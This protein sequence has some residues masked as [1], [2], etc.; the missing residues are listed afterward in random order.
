MEEGDLFEV[1]QLPGKGMG[2]L[3]ARQPRG[4]V[5]EQWYPRFGRIEGYRSALLACIA[6]VNGV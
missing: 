3:C 1:T 4:L 5:G 6:S 2:E